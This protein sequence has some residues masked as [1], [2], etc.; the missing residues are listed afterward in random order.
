MFVCTV[1]KVLVDFGHSTSTACAPDAQ[2][3]YLG[4]ERTEAGDVKQNERS[5]APPYRLGKSDVPPKPFD[6]AGRTRRASSVQISTPRA[7]P[8]RC[9]EQS[10]QRPTGTMQEPR[11]E[12]STRIAASND[13]ETR[14]G[15]KTGTI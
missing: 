9:S 8:C 4:A 5:G 10:L 14:H 7:E 11:P 12:R 13:D 3:V 6:A 2:I 15:A 1:L